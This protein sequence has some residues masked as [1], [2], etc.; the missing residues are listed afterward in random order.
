MENDT[1]SLEFITAKCPECGALLNIEADRSTAFCSYCGAKIVVHRDNEVIWHEIDDA[2]IKKAETDRIVRINEMKLRQEESQEDRKTQ[3]LKIKMGLL[4]FVAG[5]LIIIA[6][7][8]LIHA[9]YDSY[10]PSYQLIM[11][12]NILLLLG[13]IFIMH[14]FDNKKK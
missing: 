10:A 3:K 11:L 12:G 14:G 5:V 9:S 4:I 6:G 8:F 7:A 13:A 1:A 2:M